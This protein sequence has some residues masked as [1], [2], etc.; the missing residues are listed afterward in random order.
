MVVNFALL[1]YDFMISR[2]DNLFFFPVSIENDL[3]MWQEYRK[4]W[5]YF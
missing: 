5:K 1:A 3:L 4:S 2:K